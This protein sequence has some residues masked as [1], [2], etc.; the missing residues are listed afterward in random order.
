MKSRV[1]KRV[2]ALMLCMVMVL[3]SGISTLAEGDAGT[4]EATEEVSSTND[5]SAVNTEPD[6]AVAEDAQSRSNT[7]VETETAAEENAP[8]EAE[9]QP[10]TA[11]AAPAENTEADAAAQTPVEETQTEETKDNAADAQSTEQSAENGEA[12]QE[13]TTEEQGNDTSESDVQGSDSGKIPAAAVARASST[14]RDLR[15]NNITRSY[16]SLSNSETG[17]IDIAWKRSTEEQAKTYDGKVDSKPWDWSF[18]SNIG[19]GITNENLIWDGSRL[20]NSNQVDHNF[21]EST[22]LSESTVT[23]LDGTL[24]DSATWVQKT[25]GDNTTIHRFQGTFS[26]GTDNPND[27]DYT[28]KQVVDEDRI[29]INDNIFVFV[30]PVGETITNQNYMDYLAFW[31]GTV[32]GDNDDKPSWEQKDVA[33]FHGRSSTPAYW[34]VGYNNQPNTLLGKVTN[35]WYCD[36]VTDNIGNII[37]NA[38]N[39]DNGNTEFVIDVFA[40]DFAAGGGMYRL[41]LNKTPTTRHTISFMKVDEGNTD[42]GLPGAEFALSSDNGTRYT[43]TN[44]NGLITFSA[45]AG[46]YTMTETVTPSG[47]EE[48]SGKTWTVVIGSN[49]QLTIT[50]NQTSQRVPQKNFNGTSY[51]YI[52]NK[53]LITGKLEFT[54]TKADGETPLSGA[55]FTLY[56]PDG[57]TI[58][59]IASSNDQGKVVISNIPIG[60]GY[61]LKETEVPD[62]YVL[63]DDTWIVNVDSQGNVTMYLSTD[64][65]QTPV[66]VIPNYTESE[67]LLKGLENNKT[68]T[69]EDEAN[70]VFKVLLNAY[71]TGSTTTG[72]MSDIDVMFVLDKSPSMSSNYYGN[73][74][75]KDWLDAAVQS[76]ISQLVEY[77]RDGQLTDSRVAI[78]EFDDGGSNRTDGWISDIGSLEWYSNN[79][80]LTTWNVSGTSMRA[81]LQTAFDNY[82]NNGNYNSSNKQIII[83]LTDGENNSGAGWIDREYYNNDNAALRYAEKIRAKVPG[84]TLYGIGLGIDEYSGART[85]MSNLIADASK[86]WFVS[87]NEG[88]EKLSQVF[89]DIFQ[90]STETDVYKNAKVIDYID[91]RFQYSYTENGEWKVYTDEYIQ[92]YQA[93]NDGA[94]IELDNGGVLKYDTEKKCQYIEW[95]QDIGAK[96]TE[97]EFTKNFYIKAKEDFIGGNMVPTNGAESG[98]YLDD[99]TIKYF[100]QPSVN[101]AP[102]SLELTGK[103]ITVYKGDSID[104]AKFISELTSSLKVTELDGQ[105]K[106]ITG[107]PT[108]PTLTDEQKEA[109]A[110][111][112]E[113]VIGQ[114]GENEYA[115][116]ETGD[117]IGYFKYTYK[118]EEKPAINMSEHAMTESGENVA[119]Y[120]LKVEFVPYSVAERDALEELGDDVQ[121]PATNGGTELVLTDPT[122]GDKLTADAKYVVDVISGEIQITKELKENA[123]SDQSF[124][125]NITKDG[126]EFATIVININEGEKTATYEGDKL[127]DLPRGTYVVT[128]EMQG[129]AVTNIVIG[130]DTDCYHSDLNIEQ[131]TVTFHLGQD[132]EDVNVINE[133][134]KHIGEGIL[135]TVTYTNDQAVSSWQIIKRSESNHANY[136]EGAV[137]KL[138]SEEDTYYGMSNESGIIEWFVKNPMDSDFDKETDKLETGIPKG[139]Y[140]FSELRAPSGYAVSGETWEIEFAS[141]GKISSIISSKDQDK[142]MVDDV[143]NGGQTAIFYFDN[144]MLYELPEAGGTGIYWYMLGG[145][146]LMMAGSL[147]VYKKRRGEVLRSK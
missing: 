142:N 2:I 28:L 104:P 131:G 85:F 113:V 73:A 120:S 137:F 47:Y 50:D 92:D 86:L 56:E 122:T 24:Y 44:T 39:E 121:Q 12:V 15:G 30:Y 139:T 140:Q 84:I 45:P 87:D 110:T 76:F 65:D 141:L 61:I 143:L 88:G 112:D 7:A 32:G 66:S 80:S 108:I 54:K 26:I 124:T 57:T 71:S 81:G 114:A 20:N 1:K 95:T 99:T 35:G 102:L 146:L 107:I 72:S 16:G 134:L 98:V 82:Y 83:T 63:S 33:Y 52:T 51:Y 37:Y 43:S 145:V 40:E 9:A 144:E 119:V 3:S 59:G 53:S 138:E 136:L 118:V 100:P 25:G 103:E 42:L 133:E 111:G 67:E 27:F 129:Y 135:G 38:Y 70:R 36:A 29:Y 96:D 91:S 69:S 132:K 115:Y 60:T 78:V 97:D 21:S 23:A 11:E 147:L 94:G 106:V 125:F 18:V 90:S 68:V 19:L 109:L 89:S 128:E 75:R 55:T 8:A 17:D 13:E 117:P 14:I 79:Y 22:Y 4:P 123:S 127:K 74:D 77:K 105:T 126:T 6:T 49:G 46:T 116:L 5:E 41:Q 101:V 10:K 58:V 34:D 62:T 31:T 64:S 93:T 130:A 48:N